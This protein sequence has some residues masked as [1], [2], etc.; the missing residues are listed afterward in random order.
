[1]VSA[2]NCRAA[3]ATAD[4]AADND[5]ATRLRDEEISNLAETGRVAFGI[6]YNEREEDP[7]KAVANALLSYDD[8]LFRIF[9]NGIDAGEAANPVRLNESDLVTVVRLTLLSGRMW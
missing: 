6:V 5:T 1:L 3:K 2:F 7:E 9:I 4:I 8:G